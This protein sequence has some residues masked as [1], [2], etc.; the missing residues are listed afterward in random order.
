MKK[1]NLEVSVLKNIVDNLLLFKSGSNACVFRIGTKVASEDKLQSSVTIVNG[2]TQSEIAFFAVTPADYEPL[3]NNGVAVPYVTF[4]CKADA[5]TSVANALLAYEESITISV[6]GNKVALAANTKANVEIPLVAEDDLEATLPSVPKNGPIVAVQGKADSF[7]SI[8]KKGA[9]LRNDKCQ[10]H[11][12]DRV[13]IELVGADKI[14]AYSTNSF[15]FAAATANVQTKYNIPQLAMFRLRLMAEKLKDEEKASFE[16]EVKAQ[17][18]DTTGKQLVEFAKG[19]GVSLD[20]FAFSLLHTSFFIMK[21]LISTCEMF[22]IA[23]TDNYCYLMAGNVM[24]TFTLGNTVPTV[25][26]QA[27]VNF[28]RPSASDSVV[29]DCNVLQKGLAVLSL[30]GAEGKKTVSPSFVE[31]S[32]EGLKLT[33]KGSSVLSPYIEKKGSGTSKCF[34]DA[35]L[36]KE[37]VSSLD[38]GNVVFT[39]REGVGVPVEIR[40]GSLADNATSL[41]FILQVD[42]NKVATEEKSGSDET[43]SES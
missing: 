16:Q 36:L 34:L 41:A 43:D 10:H 15:A 13:V 14:S 38:S 27:V 5:F 1:F 28:T 20:R 39:F 6:D 40:N 21:K 37:T 11:V 8:A 31:V 25:V 30:I 12:G 33:K 42:P 3:E 24:A 19:K 26:Q 32:S 23:V 35:E 22:K 7:M 4:A 18:Q 9:F 17:M 2:G 29:V